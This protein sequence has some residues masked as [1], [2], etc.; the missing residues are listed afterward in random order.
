MHG[1][2]EGSLGRGN[3]TVGDDWRAHR[4]WSSRVLSGISDL[5]VIKREMRGHR[6]RERKPRA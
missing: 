2:G 6:V 1:Q 3:R 4:G 5:I